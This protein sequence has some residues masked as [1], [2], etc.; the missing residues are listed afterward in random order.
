MKTLRIDIDETPFPHALAQLIAI[1]EKQMPI[2]Q[3]DRRGG[4]RPGRPPRGIGYTGPPVSAMRDNPAE[5]LPSRACARRYMSSITGWRHQDRPMRSAFDVERW[6]K[7][8]HRRRRRRGAGPE[9]TQGP[10]ERQGDP[11]ARFPLLQLPKNSHSP[12]NALYGLPCGSAPPSSIPD[13]DC[14]P[15][16]TADIVR[17]A[18]DGQGYGVE[19]RT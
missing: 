18:P 8:V 3:P 14:L 15:D 4:D 7:P 13:P 9:V 6:S 2:V 5:S 11:P 17:K 12:V 10:W 19:T 16:K 1:Y